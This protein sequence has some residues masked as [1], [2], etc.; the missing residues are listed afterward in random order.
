MC[1]KQWEGVLGGR[2]QKAASALHES[3]R[4]FKLA[5]DEMPAQAAMLIVSRLDRQVMKQSQS[6]LGSAA[7]WEEST[8]CNRMDAVVIKRLVQVQL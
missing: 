1:T 8:L 3:L 6:N 7:S 4:Q 2:Q 5:I